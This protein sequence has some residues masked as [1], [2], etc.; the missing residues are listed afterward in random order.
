[1]CARRISHTEARSARRQRGFREWVQGPPWRWH[2]RVP[3]AAREV[4]QGVGRFPGRETCQCV[5]AGSAVPRS[6][7]WHDQRGASAPAMR[8]EW[9]APLAPLTKSWSSRRAWTRA[10]TH[11]RT[12]AAS[13]S[14]VGWHAPEYRAG[15]SCRDRS[16]RSAFSTNGRSGAHTFA[17]FP[18]GNLLDLPFGVG[19]AASTTARGRCEPPRD[20]AV[21]RGTRLRSCRQVDAC[22]VV[23]GPGR[24][25]R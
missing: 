15:S 6:R 21:S 13:R 2:S 14:L 20:R 1:M 17:G 22:R 4:E 3:E 10:A 11:E 16:P 9:E 23:G 5:R 18:P 8:L 19:L 25:G 24:T 7:R 12:P